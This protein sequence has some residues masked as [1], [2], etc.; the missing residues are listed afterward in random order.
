MPAVGFELPED[1]LAA[2]WDNDPMPPLARQVV[3]FNGLVEKVQR[4]VT[5][6]HQGTNTEVDPVI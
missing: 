3:R 6:E 5:A 2:F 1:R 4:L